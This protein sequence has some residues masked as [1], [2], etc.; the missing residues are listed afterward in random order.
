MDL[1]RI[2]ELRDAP[3]P[4][5]C[6]L[7]DGLPRPASDAEVM[8]VTSPLNGA[9]LTTLAKGTRADADAAVRAARRAFDS[10]LWS[11]KPPADRKAI[12]LKWADLIEANALEIAVLGL[13][14]IHI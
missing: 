14:L 1:S 6:H 4:P 2:A 9:V 11:D 5:A 8:Q 10:G 12:L 3:V 13:S 7:I